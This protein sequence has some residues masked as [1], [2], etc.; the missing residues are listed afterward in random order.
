MLVGTPRTPGQGW[1]GRTMAPMQA[2]TP[3]DTSCR[4]RPGTAFRAP[5]TGS[6]AS[7][8]RAWPTSRRTRRSRSSDADLALRP[9]PGLCR[10]GDSGDARRRPSS[11]RSAFRGARRWSSARAARSAR[12]WPPRAPRSP[13]AS[14]PTSPAAPTT[15]RRR[16]A[17][18]TAS[19]TTSPSRAH[20][21]G[22]AARRARRR[23]A[24]SSSIDLDVHQ[25]D[26]TA[27]IFAGD[28]ERV[29]D[30]APRREELPV[31]QGRERPRR[32]R[33]PTAAATPT[34]SPRSTAPSTGAGAAHAAARR[35]AW[36]S[37]SPAP[38][39]TRATGSAGSS[40]APPACSRATAASSPRLGERGIP[41][42]LAM[43]GGYG[44][45]LD[46]TVAIQAATIEAAIDAWRAWRDRC[47]RG[48]AP[49][50]VRAA[51][52]LPPTIRAP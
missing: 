43:A 12:P 41:V 20:A 46:V 39:R 3:T 26:G 28:A 7:A 48:A 1:P 9:R 33:C 17:A 25:G 15:R 35:S 8:S 21:A 50:R 23:A 40:S 32:R 44:H 18:A 42:A 27:A 5:S 36:P 34:T 47:G 10:G 30:L 2:S 38:I 29:H 19:S 37:T 16:A 51:R 31:P 24:R 49:R 22:R 45:D 6:C 11:A 14:P 13:K 4:C 52:R